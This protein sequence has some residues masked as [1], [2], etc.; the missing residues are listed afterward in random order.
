[1]LVANIGVVA[2]PSDLHAAD[3]DG[4]GQLDY[5]LFNSATGRTLIGYLQ[6]PTV[7]GV[8]FGPTI[9]LTWPLGGYSRFLMETEI[10]ITYSTTSPVV[11]PQSSTLKTLSRSMLR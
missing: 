3:S 11:K 6:G 5:A 1:M 4:D 7:I 9:P 2:R 10:R 8:A